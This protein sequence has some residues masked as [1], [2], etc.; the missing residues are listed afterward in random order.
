M[1]LP[2]TDRHR[3][4]YG[5]LCGSLKY[6]YSRARI[7]TPSNILDSAGFPGGD[8]CRAIFVGGAGSVRIVN[9]E[10][11]PITVDLIAGA[12]QLLKIRA[13]RINASGTT[14]SSMLALY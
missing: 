4:S 12:G 13:R 3:G 9:A 1:D 14:A 10:A 2:A 6:P 8:V 11:N 7:I 5:G